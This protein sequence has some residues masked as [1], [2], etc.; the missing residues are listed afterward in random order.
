MSIAVLF[1]LRKELKRLAIAGSDLAKGD[2]RLQKLVAPL[3]KSGETAPVFRRLAEMLEQLA[4]PPGTPTEKSS[5]TP[6]GEGRSGSFM[7]L[8][9][10]VDAVLYTQCRAGADGSLRELDAV[11]MDFRTDSTFRTLQP[12]LEALITRGAGRYEIIQQAFRNG[13]FN[14]L[15]LI[16]PAVNGLDDTYAEASDFLNNQVVPA[17]GN[18]VL[19]IL[20]KTLDFTGGKGHARRLELIAALS[21]AEGNSLYLE[22]LEKGSLEVKKSAI[23]ALSLDPANEPLLI[24]LTSDRKKEIRQ[25]AL[26]A[27]AGFKSQAAVDA[28]KKAVDAAKKKEREHAGKK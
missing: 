10:L 27:L 2:F 26:S 3:Q 18:A 24:S 1:E 22:A 4:L 9:T 8:V 6:D 19:P 21:G 7:E 11:S 15:R 14:D 16:M 28:V 5:E 17:Y 20:L 23:R 25:A 13:L 12:V